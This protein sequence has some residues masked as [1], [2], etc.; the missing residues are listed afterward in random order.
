MTLDEQVYE[1]QEIVDKLEYI[2]VQHTDVLHG[3]AHNQATIDNSLNRIQTLLTTYIS[4]VH[5][6]LDD[7]I[8]MGSLS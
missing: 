7:L 2:L 1:L 5:H 3:I 8:N 4:K 6:K